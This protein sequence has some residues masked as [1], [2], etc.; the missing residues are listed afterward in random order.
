MEKCS[1]LEMRKN[2]ETVEQY[3][4]AGIDFVVVPVLS[5]NDKN[6]VLLLASQRLDTLIELSEHKEK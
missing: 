1:P 3:K 5:E 6:K 4:K 2:L